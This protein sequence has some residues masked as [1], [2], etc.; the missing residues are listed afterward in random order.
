MSVTLFWIV[1]YTG[2][3]LYHQTIRP[4]PN[5]PWE[6]GLF[7]HAVLW[8]RG[9]SPYS[10]PASQYVTHMYGPL[11]TVIPGLLF[12]FIEPSVYIFR[13]IS[14]LSL[15]GLV[16]LT[17]AVVRRWSAVSLALALAL[18]VAASNILG[19]FVDARMDMLALFLSGV[20]SCALY[21]G[22][23]RDRFAMFLLG[24]ATIGVILFVRQ[25]AIMVAGVP[26]LY[27]A[28]HFRQKSPTR[29]VIYSLLPLAVPAV[30]LLGVW[31]T[32][33]QVFHYMVQVGGQFAIP[34]ERILR[35]TLELI[36]VTPLLW[37]L[38]AFLGWKGQL[39]PSTISFRDS[40]LFCMF[41]VMAPACVLVSSKVGGDNN[42]L[43]HAVWVAMVIVCALTPRAEAL[44]VAAA[45]SPAAQ[46][47]LAVLIAACLFVAARPLTLPKWYLGGYGGPEYRDV[48]DWA[49]K[50]TAKKVVCPQDPT[51]TFLANGFIGRVL[52]FE[53]DAAGWPDAQPD[54]FFSDIDGADV[55]ITIGNP[56]TGV[57][58][59]F[60][61]AEKRLSDMGYEPW[62]MG[63]LATSEYQVWRRKPPRHA[64]PLW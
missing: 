23:A 37:L 39:K 21:Q 3:V 44:W 13:A 30:L 35:Q 52:V 59:P 9:E 62:P 17:I 22:V 38:L 31:K 56:F 18:L 36:R 55:V 24:C 2:P 16:L 32:S 27:C 12:R 19:N 25:P 45:R 53:H 10:N 29:I 6:A 48:I 8:A 57:M 47:A 40:F 33:P 28:L 63:W 5:S 42:S 15:L 1:A 34:P 7:A 26:L 49:R 14:L 41:A 51:V 60:I 20:A 50:Q 11:Q 54:Y 64:T 43:S 58:W 4:W 46:F 61:A